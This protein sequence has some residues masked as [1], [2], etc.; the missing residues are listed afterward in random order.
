M[1]R[2]LGYLNVCVRTHKGCCDCDF[3]VAVRFLRGDMPLNREIEASRRTKRVHFSFELLVS[4]CWCAHDETRKIDC[5]PHP[6]QEDFLVAKIKG[7]GEAHRL[8]IGDVGETL[9]TVRN[10]QTLQA[11]YVEKGRRSNLAGPASQKDGSRY[12]ILHQDNSSKQ[13]FLK[14]KISACSLD[15]VRGMCSPH[16]LQRTVRLFLR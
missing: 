3:M 15:N 8:G 4:R 5:L 11:L 6:I 12:Q 2:G 14:K 9:Q 1:V 7:R 16:L 13:S 10:L